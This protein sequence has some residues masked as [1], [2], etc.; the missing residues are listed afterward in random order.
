MLA[1]N[2]PSAVLLHHYVGS[3][4]RLLELLTEGLEVPYTIKQASRIKTL[5]FA[6]SERMYT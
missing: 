6:D 5:Q 1:G 3:T 2:V 4:P